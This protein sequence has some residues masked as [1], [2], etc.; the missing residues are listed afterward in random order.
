MALLTGSGSL[1]PKHDS[2]GLSP[3]RKTQASSVLSESS[4]KTA[5]LP[6]GVYAN[7]ASA[8][9]YTQPPM[10]SSRSLHPISPI[11]YKNRFSNMTASPPCLPSSTRMS[12][13]PIASPGS[14]R[15]QATWL[16]SIDDTRDDENG[17][18]FLVLSQTAFQLGQSNTTFSEAEEK[19]RI[20]HAKD[21]GICIDDLDEGSVPAVPKPE[22]HRGSQNPGGGYCKKCRRS[23]RDKRGSKEA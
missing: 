1:T 19:Q 10:A 21:D 23:E 3:S 11:T 17:G 16:S 4:Y 9:A 22:G 8:R 5:P 7:K 15:P 6:P 20:V 18:K 12:P 2:S 14:N 13:S